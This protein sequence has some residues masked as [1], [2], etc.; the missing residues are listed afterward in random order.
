ML[1][2]YHH[3]LRSKWLDRKRNRRVDHLIHT[4]VT[5]MV[6]SYTVQHVHQEC[7]AGDGHTVRLGL[8]ECEGGSFG[9]YLATAC[10]DAG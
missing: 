5:I 6:P 9:V 4:L 2:S 1:S 8:V 7:Y 3:V 10:A